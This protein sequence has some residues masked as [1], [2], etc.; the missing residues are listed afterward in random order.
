MNLLRTASDNA[1]PAVASPLEKKEGIDQDPI[2]AP[3]IAEHAPLPVGNAP[4]PREKM[5]REQYRNDLLC[6]LKPFLSRERCEAV[7]MILRLSALGN[8]LKQLQ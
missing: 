5:R 1:A 2:S 3:T 7:D 4:S 8:V 6:A